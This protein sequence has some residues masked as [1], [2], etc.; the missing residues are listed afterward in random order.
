MDRLSKQRSSLLYEVIDSTVFYRGHAEKASR[1]A[2]NV[3]FKLPTKELEEKFLRETTEQ[4]FIGLKG[5]RLLGGFRASLYNAF[6]LE[7]VAKLAEFMQAFARK[8]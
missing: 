2:M 3:T 1:S 5:H 6:P 4:G 8:N 7:G